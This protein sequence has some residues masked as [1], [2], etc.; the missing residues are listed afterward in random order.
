MFGL[1]KRNKQQPGQTFLIEPENP[2]NYDSVLDYL[3]GLSK[4]DY[5]KLI[6]V[7]NIYRNANKDAARVLGVRDQP[8]TQLKEE[9][10][11][12]GAVDAA[13]D[14]MLQQDDLTTAFLDDAAQPAPEIKKEQAPSA[15]K[16]IKINEG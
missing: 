11:T 16:K 3:V 6:K 15:D 5:E 7:S 10:P 2:V 12:E 8:T 9:K 13:L 14:N 4:F 1:T